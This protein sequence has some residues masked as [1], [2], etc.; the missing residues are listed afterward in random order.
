MLQ[1]RLIGKNKV[2]VVL[3][4]S[5]SNKVNEAADKVF[6]ILPARFRA[7]GLPYSV[8][9]ELSKDAQIT[10]LKIGCA[11]GIENQTKLPIDRLRSLALMEATKIVPCCEQLKGEDLYNRIGEI[12]DNTIHGAKHALVAKHFGLSIAWAQKHTAIGKQ[13]YPQYFKSCNK[14]KQKKEKVK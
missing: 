8:E 1:E 7:N 12:Y 14:T 9:F 2:Q 6:T 4:K 11:T 3:V 13:K 10:N 5:F